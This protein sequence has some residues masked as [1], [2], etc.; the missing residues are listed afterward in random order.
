MN[1]VTL[2]RIVTAAAK[3]LRYVYIVRLSFGL[4]IFVCGRVKNSYRKSAQKPT[5]CKSRELHNEHCSCVFETIGKRLYN[6]YPTPG[7]FGCTCLRPLARRAVMASCFSVAVESFKN[8]RKIKNNALTIFGTLR[9][10]AGAET[11]T[12]EII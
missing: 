4:N 5:T 6:G 8:N 9:R 10:R 3:K 2:R 1:I 7:H 11:G 12:N